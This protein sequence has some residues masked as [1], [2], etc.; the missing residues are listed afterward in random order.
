TLRVGRALA[1]DEAHEHRALGEARL[2]DRLRRDVARHDADPAA[3]DAAVLQ[4]R[5]HDPAHQVDR[6]RE[7][8]ALDAGLAPGD[9]AVEPHEFSARID[10]RAARVAEIDRGVG[11][12][13]VL[14]GADAELAAPGRADD[15]LGHRLPE[16]ERVADGEHRLADAQFVGAT[17]RHDR[18]RAEA[19]LEDREVRVRIDADESRRAGL[20]VLQL[21]LDLLRLCYHM[22]VG[23][24]VTLH[25][26]D[27]PG[28]EAALD[29]LA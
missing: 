8:D 26:P 29:A 24:D 5:V 16:A 7:A 18:Q 1:V 13:E 10:E 23:D 2:L 20:A 19:D 27:N 21:H 25:V 12:D 28:S 15:A 17:D 14:E 11:L 22:E 6:D 3:H 4:D 9:R